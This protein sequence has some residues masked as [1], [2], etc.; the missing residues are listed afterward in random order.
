MQVDAIFKAAA[1]AANSERIKLAK[2]AV[3]ETRMVRMRCAALCSALLCCAVLC[4]MQHLSLPSLLPLLGP[5]R[6]HHGAF[7][8]WL[9]LLPCC[10]GP[11][12][13]TQQ[14]RSP[15]CRRWPMSAHAQEHSAAG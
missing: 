15:A 10:A 13:G 3:T 6:R 1:L 12:P 14:R 11:R 8:R 9:P 2:M 4:C 7:P 5:V